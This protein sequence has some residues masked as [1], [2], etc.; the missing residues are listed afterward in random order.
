MFKRSKAQLGKDA[1]GA[2]DDGQRYIG[3]CAKCD[4][5]GPKRSTIDAAGR[6]ADGHTKRMHGG[7]NSNAYVEAAAR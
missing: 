3:G 1:N 7:K 4:M 6:D 5:R 2:R